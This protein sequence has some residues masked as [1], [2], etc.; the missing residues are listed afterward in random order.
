MIS[1]VAQNNQL[2]LQ[3]YTNELASLLQLFLNNHQSKSSPSSSSS[4]SPSHSISSFSMHQQMNIRSECLK[5]MSIL[6]YNNG[7]H[8][9][10]K[11]HQPLLDSLVSLIS[12]QSISHGHG[13]NN[14]TLINHEIRR[15]ATISIGNITVLCGSKLNKLYPMLFEKLYSNLEKLAL[16]LASN[17]KQIIKLTCSTLRSL[18][19]LLTQCKSV[20]DSKASMLFNLLK[21]LMFFGTTI[22]PNAVLPSQLHQVDAS[23]LNPKYRAKKHGGQDNGMGDGLGHGI[24]S[25]DSD[26]DE[27]HTYAKIRISALTLLQTLCKSSPKVFFGHWAT[28]LPLKSTMPSVYTTALYD[29]DYRARQ[30]A[31]HLLTTMYDGSKDFLV[32]IPKQQTQQQS[33]PHSQAQQSTT[34]TSYSQNLAT[35]IIESHKALQSV[36]DQER[37]SPTPTPTPLLVTAIKCLTMLITNTPYEKLEKNLLRTLFKSVAPFILNPSVET[38]QATLG[39]IQSLLLADPPVPDALTTEIESSGL[40]DKFIQFASTSANGDQ[41]RNEAILCILALTKHNFQVFCLHHAPIYNIMFPILTNT[42]LD[43]TLRVQAS[44]TIEEVSKCIHESQKSTDA[45]PYNPNVEKQLWHLFFQALTGL[46][47][48]PLPQ[49]RSSIC[50]CLSHLT[51]NIFSGLPIPMQLHCVTVILGLMSDESYLVRAGACRTIG[52][53]V[54]LDTL[55]DDTTF[56]SKAASCLY[57]S[58]CDNNINVRIKACWSLA[59]LCDHLVSIRKNEEFNDIPTLILSKVV[60][61]LL[62]ASYDNPKVRCNAVRALGN[63]ARFV[64]KDLLDNT[65]PVDIQDIF[66]TINKNQQQQ[67]QPHQLQQQQQQSPVGNQPLPDQQLQQTNLSTQKNMIDNYVRNHNKSL[68]D[69]VIDSLV[70][71]AGEPSTSFNFVKVKWN[72]CYALGNLFYNPD[73]QFDP[74]P[75]WLHQVYSTLISL[76]QSCKNYKIKINASASLA[77]VTHTR[78]QYGNDYQRILE[79]IVISLS[80]INT[81]I[82]H[83]EYQYKDILERQLGISLVHLLGSMNME[84]IQSYK[85]LLVGHL[86][87]LF[88][89]V[90]RLNPVY[91]TSLI[92]DGNNTTS[93]LQKR[94]QERPTLDEFTKCVSTIERMLHIVTND[95]IQDPTLLNKIGRLQ[96]LI[97]NEGINI[98]QLSLISNPNALDNQSFNSNSNSNSNSNE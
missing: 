30:A 98:E 58:M 28:F 24:S 33:H 79:A 51:S 91:E 31:L 43:A 44:R 56:L 59:N 82:E 68:I 63:F 54:K 86:D 78:I 27:R 85:G 48:D 55:S 32:A 88:D 50:N 77:T 2:L 90:Q 64:P 35:M 29:A 69:R 23:S 36:L 4:S 16:Q 96:E 62:L 3:D 70:V 53:F 52:M 20:Y 87:V 72:A 71:N 38:Q 17:D 22:N 10:T 83:S 81:L 34:F 40:I 57:K 6:L 84:E 47:E 13:H 92:L 75:S 5:A 80:S 67:P 21:R 42:S 65:N 39:C 95:K 49:I 73:I 14:N 97:E 89:T 8:L 60:E 25:S 19:L 7:P 41:I 15:L 46:I 61:V 12:L 94:Q 26:F 37:T 76:V 11:F 45:L 93:S 9:P 18:Q 74:V 1:I 66:D